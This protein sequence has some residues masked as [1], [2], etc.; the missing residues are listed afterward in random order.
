MKL[1]GLAYKIPFMD[2]ILCVL[3]NTGTYYKKYV[4]TMAQ[5]TSY[6]IHKL[7]KFVSLIPEGLYAAGANT[8]KRTVVAWY[9]RD[10][11]HFLLCY[12]QKE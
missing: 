3:S 6:V 5:N 7:C 9:I 8:L 10:A 4:I 12:P 1:L 2:L 11:E